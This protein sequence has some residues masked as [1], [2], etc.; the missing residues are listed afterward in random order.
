MHEF[1]ELRIQLG[2]SQPALAKK[3]KISLSSVVGYEREATPE[4]MKKMRKL[5][6]AI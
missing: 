1:K 6:R 5:V 3:L 2:L 4:I